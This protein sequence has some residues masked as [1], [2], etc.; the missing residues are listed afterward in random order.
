MSLSF[1]T[2]FFTLVR[3]RVHLLPTQLTS[4]NGRSC[5]TKCIRKCSAIAAD[6]AD[7]DR[8]QRMQMRFTKRAEHRG[9]EMRCQHDHRHLFGTDGQM[10]LRSQP[11]QFRLTPRLTQFG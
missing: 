11:N 4:S 8:R 6:R 1:V 7:F 10:V 3:P 5:L 9:V 2:E